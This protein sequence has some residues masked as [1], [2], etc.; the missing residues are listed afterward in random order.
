MKYST[1]RRLGFTTIS[2][3]LL[4]YF[5]KLGISLEE[6]VLIIELEAYYQKGETFPDNQMLAKNLNLSEQT[7]AGI[8]QRLLDK[9]LLNLEQTRNNAGQYGNRYNLDPLYEKLDQLMINEHSQDVTD[10]SETIS[11][12]KADPLNDLVKAFEME[13]GRFLSPIER[14]QV[15]GWLQED[16]YPIE[17]IK[18]A[19]RESILTQVYSLK[20]IDRILLNWSRQNLKTVQEVKRYLKRNQ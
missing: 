11:L 10:T 6:L 3:G 17:I 14:Q 2:N 5:S 13:F 12:T 9:K 8:L 20:Y 18:L 7:V 16:H 1:Y 19:L 4:A 15:Q